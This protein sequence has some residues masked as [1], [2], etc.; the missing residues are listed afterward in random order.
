MNFLLAGFDHEKP[1]RQDSVLALGQD[2]EAMKAFHLERRRHTEDIVGLLE[3]RVEAETTYAMRL[4]KI[5][6]SPE[7]SSFGVGRLAEEVAS[8]KG[9]CFSRAS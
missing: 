7:S 5:S 1:N 6:N 8:F 2:Y 3:D 9:S 4:E